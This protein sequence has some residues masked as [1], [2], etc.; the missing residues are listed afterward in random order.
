[1]F[2][3]FADSDYVLFRALA[4][5]D[6]PRQ[7]LHHLQQSVEKYL[8]S[9]ILGSGGP[10]GRRTHDLVNL[11]QRAA[12]SCPT[13]ADASFAKFCRLLGPYQEWG[14]YPEPLFDQVYWTPNWNKG[15]LDGVSEA[16]FVVATLREFSIVELGR[17]SD[18]AY[19]LEAL[20]HREVPFDAMD[21]PDEVAQQAL[22]ACLLERNRFISIERLPTES[23]RMQAHAVFPMLPLPRRHPDYW[24][25]LGRSGPP[26][27]T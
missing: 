26:S 14:H 9:I 5:A 6:L 1:L 25:R 3:A 17:T 12:E 15:R 24:R 10:L 8:K 11:Q 19:L 20:A 4:L 13:L 22:R 27:A 21:G 23:Q 16:D 2:L 18:A 7:A